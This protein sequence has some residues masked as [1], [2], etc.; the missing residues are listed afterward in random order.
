MIEESFRVTKSD[1]ETRPVYASTEDH[2]EAHFLICFISLVIA[3]LLEKRLG[4]KYSITAILQSLE[5]SSCSLM[6]QNLYLFDYFDDVLRALT[7]T[8]NIDFRKKYRTLKE[9]KKI[10]GDTKKTG[11]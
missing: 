6:E 7:K 9:I 8:F 10:V 4:H 11:A 1:L 3:K 5:R 2:I